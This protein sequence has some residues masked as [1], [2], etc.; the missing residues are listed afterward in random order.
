MPQ[1]E[2]S[3]QK[4]DLFVEFVVEI[5]KKFNKKQ[6]ELWNEFFQNK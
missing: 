2:F 3:S 4:G 5:D 6:V 1:H